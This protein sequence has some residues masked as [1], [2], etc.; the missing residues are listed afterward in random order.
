MAQKRRSGGGVRNVLL[1]VIMIGAIGF[2]LFTFAQK[3]DIHS[4]GDIYDYAHGVGEKVNE[5]GASNL[6]WNCEGIGPD[7]KIKEPDN[8]L[9]KANY[10]EA[11]K[12]LDSIPVKEKTDAEYNRSDYKHWVS[13][14]DFGKG[15]NTRK[16]ILIQ[17]G[18]N[19]KTDPKTCKITSGE[20]NDPYSGQVITNQSKIDIDHILPLNYVNQLA[21][22][23]GWDAQK[24]QDYAND[25]DV[26]LAVSA[27]ENRQKSD[28]GP[29][30]WMPSNEN[31]HCQYSQ[32]IVSVA[33]KYNF[34]LPKADHDKLDDVLSKCAK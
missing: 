23:A 28:K 14:S 29:S 11:L 19:I 2:G 18:E 30:E 12:T 31:Y 3:N 22:V 16:M 6:E 24:K 7:A 1:S 4:L 26:L 33:K 15:C 20:W 34:S 17:Q 21:G 32:Q 9:T 25:P 13:Q 8:D 10:V 27:S 5:C